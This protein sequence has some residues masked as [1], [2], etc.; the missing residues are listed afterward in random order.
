MDETY[1][2]NMKRMQDSEVNFF[3][4][5]YQNRVSGAFNKNRKAQVFLPGT[6]VYCWRKD[7]RETK[8]SFKGTAR[9]FCTE[10]RDNE[11]GSTGQL[12]CCSDRSAQEQQHTR[13]RLVTKKPNPEAARAATPCLQVQ[14]R[15]HLW[16]QNQT[17]AQV[18]H[19]WRFTLR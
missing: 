7:K 8:G 11:K 1:G 18:T 9:V 14:P 2:N 4:W 13:E 6:Y 15:R 10:T 19:R 16:I 3:R 12:P 5:T 17:G